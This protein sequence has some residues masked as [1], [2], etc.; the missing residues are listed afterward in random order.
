MGRSKALLT[1]AAGATFVA[2]LVSTLLEG[3]VADA[4]VVGRPDDRPLRHEV[5]RIHGRVQFIENPRAEQGQ[6]SSVIAGLNAA[7]R[8]GTA[9]ILVT[10]VDL[11]L[12]RPESVAALL[13]AFASSKHSIVRASHG[14]KHGHPVIFGRPVFAALRRADPDIGAKA[15]VRSHDVLD[16]EVGDAGVLYDIDT[17][18][19]YER[20]R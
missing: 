19:D 8:P 20:I 10:P 11:P 2:Q 3:G 1:T 4:L 18:D 12:V 9:A 16:V 7:D 17:P 15:V 13:A 14:G 6:L 5:D